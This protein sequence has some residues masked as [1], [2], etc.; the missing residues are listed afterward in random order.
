M[1]YCAT[2]R[3][4]AQQWFRVRGPQFNILC[5]AKVRSWAGWNFIQ[6]EGPAAQCTAHLQYQLLHSQYIGLD[7]INVHCTCIML[8]QETFPIVTMAEVWT[9]EL[10]TCVWMGQQ[11]KVLSESWNWHNRAIILN[12]RSISTGVSNNE[13]HTFI[14]LL[15]TLLD[16]V[17]YATNV[18]VVDCLSQEHTD[19]DRNFK[20]TALQNNISLIHRACSVKSILHYITALEVVW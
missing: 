12:K 2:L 13:S 10:P 4:L 18:T 9:S 14:S 6:G 15:V 3:L 8:T 7:N 5:N 20:A 19:L 1:G 16:P 17:P 11:D